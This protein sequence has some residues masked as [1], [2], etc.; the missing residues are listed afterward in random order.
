MPNQNAEQ[1][2]RDK[3]DMMLVASGWIIQ[4]KKNLNLNAGLGI[5]AKEYQTDIGPADKFYLSINDQL[6]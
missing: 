6:A 1:I 2:A 4:S 5:V 3:I